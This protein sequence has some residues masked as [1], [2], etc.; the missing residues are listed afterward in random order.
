MISIT[1]MF[2]S[3]ILARSSVT[4]RKLICD[5]YPDDL[6]VLFADLDLNTNIDIND[7]MCIAVLIN[8][9]RSA[10]TPLSCYKQWAIDRVLNDDR[11]TNMSLIAHRDE[12]LPDQYKDHITNI[13]IA[14]FISTCDKLNLLAITSNPPLQLPTITTVINHSFRPRFIFECERIIDAYRNNY[15]IIYNNHIHLDKNSFSHITNRY[16][17]TNG[18]TSE[19]KNNMLITALEIYDD[20]AA[21]MGAILY[22]NLPNLKK[23]KYTNRLTNHG[24]DPFA[25]NQCSSLTFLDISYDTVQWFNDYPTM[26][27][28]DAHINELYNLRVL[29][30]DNNRGITTCNR[31][32]KSLREL[33]I[34]NSGLTDEGLSECTLIE[35]LIYDISCG[36]TTCDPFANSL[37]TLS[38]SFDYYR[39][40]HS[41]L[42]DISIKKCK[43]LEALLCDGNRN[44]TTC[45]PFASLR[46]LSAYSTE[47]T[48][49]ELLECINIE[50][51]NCTYN[52]HITSCEPFAQT[53]RI[54]HAYNTNITNHG[55]SECTN[56]EYLDCRNNNDITT[57]EPFAQTLRTLHASNTRITD[58]GLS[59]CINIEKLTCCNTTR[60][61]TCKPFC[62][63]LRELRAVNSNI[64]DH[65]LLQCTRITLLVCDGTLITNCE[66]FIHSL[67]TLNVGATSVIDTDAIRK[68]RNIIITITVSK[69]NGDIGFDFSAINEFFSI[70]M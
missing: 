68:H 31:F 55:L 64:T 9:D 34:G 4:L 57:C 70:H 8:I 1:T 33:S 13:G 67:K 22:E 10:N 17:A 16:R 60:I 6:C 23:L 11:C 30:C 14:N 65:G 24:H 53:L 15:N 32:A 12:L 7:F 37:R 29:I 66:P 58:Y 69:G 2:P 52:R 49:D 42:D 43:N 5:D 26:C 40:G 3:K 59:K 27:I 25:F 44:I 35:K 46:I 20:D 36:V 38:I 51:F 62:R 41:P 54:L 50:E 61:T 47:I 39:D 21:D 19:N 45:K 63:T 28:T 56:I 48:E 18:I